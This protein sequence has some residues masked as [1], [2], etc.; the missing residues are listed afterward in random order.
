[1]L[2]CTYSSRALFPN[3][4]IINNPYI[5]QTD[6][7]LTI[8]SRAH[9]PSPERLARHSHPRP[10][11]WN[12]LSLACTRLEQRGQT[13]LNHQRA[14][15]PTILLQYRARKR[16]EVRLYLI[17][18]GFAKMST[19]ALPREALGRVVKEMPER[20]KQVAALG[21]LVGVSSPPSCGV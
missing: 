14:K 13:R 9:P 20:S 10:R 15:A 18:V 1:M 21:A 8:T 2:P 19:F 7:F 16:S 17:I 11:L 3:S 4:L 12:F 6:P 5:P